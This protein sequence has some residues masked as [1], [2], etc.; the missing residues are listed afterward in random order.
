MR[1]MNSVIVC[2]LA[3]AQIAAAQKRPVTLDDIAIRPAGAFRV[4]F[5]GLHPETVS[6]SAKM[7]LSRSTT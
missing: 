1:S 3:L 2:A 4:A 6:S 5:D 7:A